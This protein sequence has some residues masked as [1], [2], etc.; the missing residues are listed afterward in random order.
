MGGEGREYAT[1]PALLFFKEMILSEPRLADM[2]Q[3]VLTQIRVHRVMARKRQRDVAALANISPSTWTEY[4]SGKMAS[5]DL[6]I[7]GRM[8]NALDLQI[9]IYLETR[10]VNDGA[11]PDG[12]RSTD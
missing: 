11:V 8:A 6:R 12:D 1:L 10:E 3:E 4:E 5:P 2:V 7:L 9:G